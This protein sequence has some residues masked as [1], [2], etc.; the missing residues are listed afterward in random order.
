[1]HRAYDIYPFT[2]MLNHMVLWLTDLLFRAN[3]ADY[4]KPRLRQLASWRAPIR[5]Y[6]LKMTL[7]LVRCVLGLL[8]L[9]ASSYS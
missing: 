9:L 8:G 1:M 5:S 2:C 7:V 4:V 3:F 6:G